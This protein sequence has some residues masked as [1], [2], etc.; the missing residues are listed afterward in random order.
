VYRRLLDR[1]RGLNSWW[2]ALA[3]AVA[4]LL[5]IHVFI[6]RFVK[7][8]STSMYAT[9]L[10]GDLVAVTRWN[11]WTGFRRGDVIVFRDPVQDD[12]PAFRRKL[13]IKRIAGMPGDTVQLIEGRLFVNREHVGP[14][15]D[16]THSYLVRMREDSDVTHLLGDLGLPSDFVPPGRSMFELPLNKAM[17]RTV[18]GHAGVVS[19]EPMRKA[20]GAPRNIFPYSPAFPWNP[21]D[22]GPIVVPRRGD[23]VRIDPVRIALYDRLISRYEGHDIDHEGDR[24]RI[25]GVAT[26]R[27]VVEQDHYFVLGDCRHFSSD[28]RFWGFVPADHVLGR[29][30]FVV[31]SSQQGSTGPRWGR[32]FKGL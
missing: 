32:V 17:A 10:P 24:L 30:A 27:Y 3:L 5:F 6:L 9:C 1:W 4:C 19:V 12:R 8:V 23:G 11:T 20:T 21:D 13:L 22:Y 14:F 2:R 28:S 15:P 25:D 7:V 31:L 16:E 26:D 29:A 18:H